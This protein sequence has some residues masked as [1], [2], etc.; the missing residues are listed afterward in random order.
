MGC[1][2]SGGASVLSTANALAGGDPN[3]S[4]SVAASLASFPNR[5][6][7]VQN[8]SAIRLWMKSSTSGFV[9]FRAKAL[10]TRRH[11]AAV[12]NVSLAAW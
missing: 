4:A 9:L 5:S 10:D 2:L 7:S 11:C 3:V 6:M 8:P 12:S 1:A